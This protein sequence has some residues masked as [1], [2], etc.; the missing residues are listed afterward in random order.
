MPLVDGERRLISA[1]TASLPSA[2]RNADRKEGGRG[3]EASSRASSASETTRMSGA[4]SRRFHAMISV[5][6]SDM[7]AHETH[8]RTRMETLFFRVFRVFRGLLL[9]HERD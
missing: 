6:L 9:N 5:S 8:E 7:F 2:R 4:I 1:I 3:S